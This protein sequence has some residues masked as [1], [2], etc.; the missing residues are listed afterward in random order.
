MIDL[1]CHILPGV[2]DGSK[3]IE[4]SLQMARLAEEEGIQKIAA[5]PHLFRKDIV[6]KSMKEI[7]EKRSKLIQALKENDVG[8]EILPGAEVYVTHNILQQVREKRDDLTLNHSSFMFIEFPTEHVFPGVK[9]LLFQLMSEQ[10][11]P[12][13]AHPER[14]RVFAQRPTLLYE[15]LQMGALAQANA[16]SFSGLYGRRAEEAV[17]RFLEMRFIHFIASDGHN[18]RLIP[19]KLSSAV[20]KASSFLSE[21]EALALVKDNPQAVLEDK[22]VPYYPEPLSPKKKKSFSIKLPHLFKNK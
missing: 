16:G 19:P 3:D 9:N 21:K 8:V 10:V 22:Q 2:D 18:S 7:K 20:E 14:N 4:E 12:I 15:L 11:I 17:Y 13:I 1:H 6:E 5:T